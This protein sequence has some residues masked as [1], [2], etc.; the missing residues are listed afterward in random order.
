M[1]KD[2]IKRRLNKRIDEDNAF[3][4][5]MSQ[6]LDAKNNDWLLRLIQKVICVIFDE[7]SSDILNWLSNKFLN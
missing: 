3:A 5:Q 2:E 6:A 7:I 1:D 4:N